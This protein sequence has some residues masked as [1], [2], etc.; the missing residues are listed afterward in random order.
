MV[1]PRIF[2]LCLLILIGL[3]VPAVAQKRVALVIGN[4]NYGTVTPLK[5]PVNDAKAVAQSLRELGFSVMLGTDLGKSG[6]EKSVLDF[7][8][9]LHGAQAA[10]FYY[11]GH[12]LQVDGRNYMVPV[13]AK[14]SD[15]ADLPFQ[16]VAMDIVLNKLVHHRITNIVIMD[17][18][19]DNPLG[20]KLSRAL[21]E[22]SN[23]VG[24]GLASVYAGAGTLI[25]YS[26][27][28][29][30]VALD[31]D[32]D[33]SIY[34]GSLA[35]HISTP[36]IDV[37]D[38]LKRVRKDV[39]DATNKEQLPWDS[40]AMVEDFFFRTSAG[41]NKNATPHPDPGRDR[42]PPKDQTAILIPPDRNAVR[43]GKP[44]VHPC[45]VI[46]G[47]ASDPER[48]TPG[49]TIGQLNG[50]EGVTACRAAL[51]QYPNTPRFEFQLARSLQKTKANE[52][53]AAL[54]RSLVERGYFAA[55]T[56]YGW[57]LNNGLGVPKDQK[58]AV[59][60]YLLAAHQGDNFGM[61]NTAMAYD[62]GEG[63]PYDPARAARW[64]YA[65]IRLGHDYS[66][67]MM[68]ERPNAWTRDFRIELQR[69]LQRAGAYDGPI[70][71]A[72]GP[73]M[74]GA[75]RR[76]KDLPFAPTPGGDVPK[77][78]FDAT[79]IPVNAPLPRR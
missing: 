37:I 44:P 79:T 19:R 50:G 54:Y 38:M 62:T 34:S 51:A 75:L 41:K 6:F 58:A 13:D 18:C 4:G 59:H 78:R 3:A 70:N 77:E 57:M 30:H 74:E 65:A 47:S 69:L 15:E 33:N 26:T 17:A 1:R 22:R 14:L 45:D 52:E 31:G 21:G 35:R 64:L 63:L 10:V 76:V 60:F 32:G 66:I 73:A 8:E 24:T 9:T 49:V 68:V 42:K 72:L 36:D 40:H 29:Y 61:F 55:L 23:A 71:G 25:S 12:G 56:N 39:Q 5:N 28:P 27:Q 67:R 11:A 7:S 46:A 48:V 53:S 20:D 43:T 2:P 16:L